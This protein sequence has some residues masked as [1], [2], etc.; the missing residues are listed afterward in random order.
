[1]VSSIVLALVRTTCTANQLVSQVVSILHSK[2]Q[3]IPAKVPLQ[4][5]IILE[6]RDTSPATVPPA[7][8]VPM[9]ACIAVISHV[10]SS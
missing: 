7:T 1:M 10:I 3:F 4:N 2:V 9:V 6:A 8:G 5:I